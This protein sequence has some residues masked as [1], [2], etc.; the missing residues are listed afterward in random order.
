M[1]GIHLSS[2]KKVLVL[3]VCIWRP[4]SECWLS[5]SQ[6]PQSTVNHLSMLNGLPV[7]SQR[8]FPRKS[9]PLPSFRDHF[10]RFFLD[11]ADAKIESAQL[12]EADAK[13]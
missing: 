5:A 2:V 13:C 8:D 9:D 7:T 10:A 12:Y 11:D 1:A 4:I 3:V 6:V